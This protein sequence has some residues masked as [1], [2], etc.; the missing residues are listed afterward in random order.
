M[1][2]GIVSNKE[3]ESEL[4]N[5][6]IHP[7][8]IPPTTSTSNEIIY[9]EP[10]ADIK[11]I[12]DG[13]RNPGDIN[14]PHSVRK[15]IGDT[16]TFNGRQDALQLASQFGISPASVSAY[17]NPANSALSE[18]NKFDIKHFL[19]KR[20]D[21][22]SKRAIGKLNMAISMISEDKLS[23]CKAIELSQVAKNMA[24]VVGTLNPPERE[25]ENKNPV[26]FHFYSPQVKNETHYEVIT[27]KDTY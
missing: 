1:P 13:G 7:D 14:V 4:T 9:Q 12:A 27:A 21:K 23:E 25:T 6:G 18:A 2:L 3:F 17:T 20:R 5:S 19:S 8:A 22:I 10:T 26:Q 16:A 24:S 11:P 15:L